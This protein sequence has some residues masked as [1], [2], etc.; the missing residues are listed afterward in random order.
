MLNLPRTSPLAGR[1]AGPSASPFDTAGLRME[2]L[3]LGNLVV[4]CHRARAEAAIA[5]VARTSGWVLPPVPNSVAV[6][7]AGRALW[8]EPG[9]WML[10]GAH[11]ALASALADLTAPPS[12]PS[13]V[14]VLATDLSAG[15]CMLKLSGPDARG[16]IESGCPVDLHPRVFTPDRCASSLFNETPIVIDQL[17]AEP[18]QAYV[19]IVDRASAANLWDQLADAARWLP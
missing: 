11:D 12:D 6:Q 2:E 3:D 10:T 7:P 19:L 1:V 4:R 14:H 9:A 8:L 17:S 15:R 13:A 16:L 5:L 18:T